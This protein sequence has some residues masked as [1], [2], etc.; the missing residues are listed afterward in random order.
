MEKSFIWRLS[1]VAIMTVF[2][3]SSFGCV[4]YDYAGRY[5]STSPEEKDALILVGVGTMITALD[6]EVVSWAGSTLFYGI[7]TTF[8]AIRIPEG[9]HTIKGGLISENGSLLYQSSS[10]FNFIA[11]KTYQVSIVNRN[12]KILETTINEAKLR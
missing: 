12:F 5:D 11:G 9:T 3:L 10:K 1:I 2:T 6:H 7:K 4:S 8:Y